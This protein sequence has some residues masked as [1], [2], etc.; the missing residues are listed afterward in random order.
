[1]TIIDTLKQIYVGKKVAVTSGTFP[2]TPYLQPKQVVD[3]IL[4][5]HSDG[6]LLVYSDG[7]KAL[8][9]ISYNLEIIE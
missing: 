7:G 3:I 4:D 2:Y 5:Q 9:R 1:M 6:I 8:V